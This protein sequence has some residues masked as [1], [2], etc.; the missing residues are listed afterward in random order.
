MDVGLGREGLLSVNVKI[1]IKV[2]EYEMRF[3]AT[4]VYCTMNI[5]PGGV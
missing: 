5:R 3:Y 1:P 2:Y 4:I